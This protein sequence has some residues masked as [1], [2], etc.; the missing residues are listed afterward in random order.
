MKKLAIIFFVL[1]Y[2]VS[3]SGLTINY[4][5]CCGKLKEISFLS[6]HTNFNKTCKGNKAI[7]GCCDTKATFLKIKDDHSP[8][9]EFKVTPS[10]Y[11]TNLFGITHI[12]IQSFFSLNESALY[13]YTHAP[14]LERKH[15]IYLSVCNFRI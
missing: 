8:S 2:V 11:L 14:P 7:P 10:N 9:Q 4:F 1:L 15:P 6:N 3:T 12:T 5:Y 13:A